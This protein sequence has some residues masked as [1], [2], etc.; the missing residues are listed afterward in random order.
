MPRWL[1]A[2]LLAG[3]I[4]LPASA[5]A[6][7]P[8]ALS[9]LQV[10]L[11]PEY[12]QPSMLVIY[13]FKLGAG[14]TLPVG[15]SIKIPA[16]ANL[17]A[18]A[19]QGADGNLM[20]ADYLESAG[21][22]TWQSVVVQIQSPTTYRIEYYQPLTRSGDQRQFS[23]RWTGEYLVE[24]FG[25]S[26]RMPPDAT[27]V[28]ADPAL[29]TTQPAGGTPFMQNDFGPLAAGE[30]FTLELNYSRSS[31][32]LTA[33]QGN[34]QPSQPLDGSTPG[35]VMLS[36]YLPYILGA[37]GLLL[38]AGGALYFWQ[39]SRAGTS[40]DKRHLSNALRAIQRTGDVYCHQCGARAQPGDRFCR[41]CGTRQRPAE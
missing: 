26:V 29:Q 25:I 7:T 10:Q 16:D 23:Y 30:Q 18:V 41:V 20:N 37:L 11:W 13:D 38:I 21:D 39:S 15:V 14:T 2:V 1:T 3:A 32:A 33:S 6:Q 12:D 5:L 34:L 4:S 22:D 19:V 17:V 35:R 36:N 27:S 28:S 8:I 31:E 40:R 24:D 9:S